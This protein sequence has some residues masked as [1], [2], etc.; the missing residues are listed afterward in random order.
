[1]KL[2]VDSAN[3]SQIKKLK[4]IFPVTGV[5]TNPSILAKESLLPQESLKEVNHLLG[6]NEEFHVQVLSEN[7]IEMK[8]E[9]YRL[10]DNYR[11]SL[12]VKIPVSEQG[13]KAI[14]M[15]SKEGVRVTATA[16]FTVQQGI[17]ASLAGADYIAPYVNRIDNH[18]ADG[19]ELIS[20]LSSFFEKEQIETKILAASFKN[21]KQIE[22]ALLHGAYSVTAPPSLVREMGSHTGT[23]DAIKGFKNDYSQAFK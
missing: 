5:T 21:T 10:L 19:I 11:D 17:L 2:L 9:A 23:S 1:M 14:G 20:K 4:N 22:D 3:L 16:V 15:L 7:A 18:N 8:E 6:P 13:Y 12:Y